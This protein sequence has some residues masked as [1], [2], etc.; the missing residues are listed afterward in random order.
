MRTEDADDGSAVG[1]IRCI[2]CGEGGEAAG[3]LL[4][5]VLCDSS[6]NSLSVCLYCHLTKILLNLKTTKEVF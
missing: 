4:T 5:E 6:L 1:Y 3:A 2:C